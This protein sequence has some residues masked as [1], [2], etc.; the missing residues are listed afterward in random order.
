MKKC[1][2]IQTKLFL[3]FQFIK[4]SKIKPVLIHQKFILHKQLN[5]FLSLFHHNKVYI[6][7]NQHTIISHVYNLIFH[8]QYKYLL[9]IYSALKH[10]RNQTQKFYCLCLIQE[11]SMN[12][13]IILQTLRCGLYTIQY[14]MI[15][16]I[17]GENKNDLFLTCI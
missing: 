11:A 12:L 7:I 8:N 13:I 16:I 6:N 1:N 5:I 10:I 15:K 4:F 2:N 14:N 9:S 3:F 17:L